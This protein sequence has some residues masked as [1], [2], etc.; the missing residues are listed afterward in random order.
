MVRAD[1]VLCNALYPSA[2]T[3][4]FSFYN[5]PSWQAARCYPLQTRIF[6]T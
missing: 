4:C 1:I 2:S 5:F 3:L 6:F